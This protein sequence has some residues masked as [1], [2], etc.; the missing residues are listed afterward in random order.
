MSG[1]G[2]FEVKLCVI[3]WRR[4]QGGKEATAGCCKARDETRDWIWSRGRVGEDLSSFTFLFP[5]P[6]WPVVM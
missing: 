2:K 3:H 6:E 5:W 4:G 1:E